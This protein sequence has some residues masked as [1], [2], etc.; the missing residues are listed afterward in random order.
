MRHSAIGVMLNTNTHLGLENATDELKRMEEL[1][2]ARK[3][4]ENFHRKCSGQSNYG[5]NNLRPAS[6][7]YFLGFFVKV[8]RCHNCK[9]VKDLL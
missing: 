9:K 5:K 8:S 1:E 2:N 4:L 3:E 6:A 7:E